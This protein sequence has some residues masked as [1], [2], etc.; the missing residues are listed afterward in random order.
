M[1]AGV[2]DHAD[3]SLAEAV[4]FQCG[5]LEQAGGGGAGINGHI[6]TDGMG[7]VDD[8]HGRTFFP[9]FFLSYHRE[10]KNDRGKLL[11]SFC[12]SAGYDLYCG[13]FLL[14]AEVQ[15]QNSNYN[16]NNCCNNK[17][18]PSI[19][20]FFVDKR[21]V[22]GPD[23]HVNQ[24]YIGAQFSQNNVDAMILQINMQDKAEEGNCA[25][26]YQHGADR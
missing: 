16:R 1:G 21:I 6:F 4:L 20:Y 23:V 22:E 8:V 7:Q 13:G 3:L 24:I 12:C 15:M 17:T 9:K 10:V 18:I 5:G 25:Y 26:M 2:R 14:F 19:V 11:L